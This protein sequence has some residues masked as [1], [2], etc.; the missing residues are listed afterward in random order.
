MNYE[1]RN[2][3]D[4]SAFAVGE[5]AVR[6]VINQEEQYCAYEMD[7]IEK[8]NAA[9]RA[10]LEVEIGWNEERERELTGILEGCEGGDAAM[11]LRRIYFAAT[12][13]LFCLASIIFAHV[14][15]QPFGLGLEILPG[16]I[17]LGLILAF[18]THPLLE[19]ESFR[20][21]IAA[22]GFLCA[23]LGVLLMAFVRG[24]VFALQ[25]NEAIA[26]SATSPEQGVQFTGQRRCS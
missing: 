14:S 21:F 24:N 4:R 11:R 13:A 20:P 12:A 19:N 25:L 7:R 3:P 8:A 6:R 10:G 22:A 2:G 9:S 5:G 1:E 16:V 15:L 18:W 26:S 17:A 23:L